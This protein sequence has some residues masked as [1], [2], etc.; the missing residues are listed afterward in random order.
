MTRCCRIGWT[1]RL[2]GI[3]GVVSLASPALAGSSDRSAAAET[4]VAT[5]S[6][7]ATAQSSQ[8]IATL[9]AFRGG[10]T[11]I[12]LGLSQTPSPSMPLELNDIV[13]TKQG[14]AT[15]RFH[16]DGSLLRIGPVSR[17]QINESATERDITVFFGR[18]WAHIVRWQ[19]RVS[20]FRSNSTIAAIRGTEVSLAVAVDGDETELSVLEGQVEAETDSGSLMLTGGQSAVG[21]K[22]VAPTLRV[23][24]RPQDAV[25]W[26]LYYLPVIYIKPSEL[27][28]GPWQ[29]RV[30]ASSEA[31]LEGDLQRAIDMLD[32]VEVQTIRDPRFFTYRA[33]LLL[34]TGSVEEAGEDI[35]RALTLAANDSDALALQTI[36]A[37]ANNEA[38][39]ALATA[40]K[41]VET[42]PSSATARIALSYAHQALF[43]LEGARE[44]LET[45]VEIEPSD[46]LTWGRLA[47]IRSSQ[48]YLDEAL[49][50]AHKAVELEP[51]LSRTQ[52]VLGYAYLTRVQTREAQEACRKAIELDQDDPLPRLGLGLALIRKGELSEGSREIEVAVSLDPGQAVVRSYLGKA[53]FE[54]K[55]TGLDER[56][57]DVAKELDPNDPTPWFYDAIFKQTTNRPIEA[58]HALQRSIELNDNRAVYRSRLLLDR[59][60]ATRST[61]LGRI[62]SDLGFEQVGLIEASKSLSLDPAEDSAHRLLSD[63]YVGLPRHDLARGSE[64]LQAQ[65]LQ[66]INSNPVRPSRA[67]SAFNIAAGAGPSDAGFNEFSPLFERNR[68][69]LLTSVFGGNNSTWGD[70]VVLSGLYDRWAAS[71]GQF[72]ADTG[73]FRTNSDAEDDLYNAFFQ[74][75][76]TPA[77]D[78]Q[79]EYQ[80][81][82]SEAGDLRL[83]FFTDDRFPLTRQGLRHDSGRIGTHLKLSPDRKSVV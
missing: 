47:E 22:G 51:N 35:G 66:P 37:V 20:R 36:I 79:A 34:A 21:R 52:T 15:V 49:E 61:S 70:E 45:A 23:R 75:A 27:G 83:R 48:G 2:V 17:V 50:V 39:N 56:E 3:V 44:S 7:A 46:A 62:Y 59:D 76:V 57:Y 65:L 41:S 38:E 30:R 40:Q 8:E 26:A 9:E 42:D 55:R 77:L 12:R 11:V 33:S 29:D 6:A 43:D 64:L 28:E 60:L 32:G 82:E 80:R 10:V 31:Y 73:G 5:A 13:V 16:S 78:L 71:L 68:W 53:Y 67:A 25:Q 4:T 58:L 19:A 74:V 81:Q 18:I 24:V 69:R 63:T 54:A 72:H 1:Q 14:R